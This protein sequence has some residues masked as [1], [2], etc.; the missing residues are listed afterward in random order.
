MCQT[1]TLALQLC[2]CYGIKSIYKEK[3]IVTALSGKLMLNKSP[4]IL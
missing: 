3:E 4:A 1:Y 2:G